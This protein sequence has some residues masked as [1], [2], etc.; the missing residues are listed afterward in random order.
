M[1]YSIPLQVDVQQ[2]E[3][4]EVMCTGMLDDLTQLG[5]IPETPIPELTPLPE[6]LL[7]DEPSI[8]F[9]ALPCDQ[10]GPCIADLEYDEEPKLAEPRIKVGPQLQRDLA[11]MVD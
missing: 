4:N 10:I 7:P 9:D 6:M 5:P 2:T 11:T 3:A 8:G 1:V